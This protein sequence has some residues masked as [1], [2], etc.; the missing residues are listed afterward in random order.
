M[1]EIEQRIK[2]FSESEKQRV[3][4]IDRES[5][6]RI[7]TVDEVEAEVSRPIDI[8]QRDAS[9][10]L[11]ESKKIRPKGS[12]SRVIAVTEKVI[13]GDGSIGLAKR[14]DE[15]EDTVEELREQGE[16]GRSEIARR[17][18]MEDVFIP[19]I[20]TVIRFSSP[21][22][23]LNCREALSALDKYAL[24]T[25]SM[26]GY[27]ASYIRQ[28]YG[29]LL[30]KDIDGRFT[31]SDQ[32]VCDAVSRIKNLVYMDSIRAAVGVANQAKKAID[33]GEHMANSDDYALLSKVANF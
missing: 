30:G 28:A 29:D 23:L 24:G 17:Q 21:D 27:T 32:F 20:E 18:Y 15:A 14:Y 16:R 8:Y 4:G 22:E 6:N 25:G 12:S 26:K 13:E 1:E 9:A 2:E 5:E 10:R 33:K 7:A 19:A 11:E 31:R 3:R